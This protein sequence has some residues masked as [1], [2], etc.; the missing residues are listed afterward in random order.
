EYVVDI[1]PH[2]HGYYLPTTG[3]QIVAPEFLREYQPDVVIIMNAVYRD[4]I[5]W[6]LARMALRP[7]ILAL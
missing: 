6:E 4:E 5:G 1:N 3:Q 7:E 2:R